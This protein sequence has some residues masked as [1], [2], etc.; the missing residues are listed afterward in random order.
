MEPLY[1]SSKAGGHTDRRD[2]IRSGFLTEE[3][4]SCGSLHGKLSTKKAGDFCAVRTKSG[5]KLSDF[6]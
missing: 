1:I 6:N 5:K 3:G 4:M 2:A